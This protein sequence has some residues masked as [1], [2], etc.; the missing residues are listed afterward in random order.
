[1]DV[2]NPYIVYLTLY[3]STAYIVTLLMILHDFGSPLWFL[4]LLL[5]SHTRATAHAAAAR[6]DDAVRLHARFICGFISRAPA[7][8]IIAHGAHGRAISGV[9]SLISRGC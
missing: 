8:D 5:G 6:D 9:N 7:R 3:F 4:P 2:F 1:V